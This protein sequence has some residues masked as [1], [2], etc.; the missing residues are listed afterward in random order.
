MGDPQ[1]EYGFSHILEVL[2]EKRYPHINFEIINTGVVAINSHAIRFIAD[3][4]LDWEPDLFIV[5]MGNNEVVGPYGAGTVLTAVQPNL[6]MIRLGLI[7]R[8]LRLGQLLHNALQ[9]FISSPVE[10]ERWLGMEMFIHNEVPA[11]DPRLE[12]VYANFRHNLDAICTNITK[13]KIPLVLSTVG[14]NL[15]DCAPFASKHREGITNAQLSQWQT[16]V[17][18][19]T[20]AEQEQ[21]WE[22]AID[23]HTQALELDDQYADLHFRIARC[24]VRQEHAEQAYQHFVQARDLDTLRFRADS[25]IN[26]IIKE[27]ASQ[28]SPQVHL[29]DMD[30]KNRR[31]SPMGIPGDNLFYEHVHL[32]FAGNYPLA[33]ECVRALDEVLP[34]PVTQQRMETLLSQEECARHLAFTVWDQYQISRELL[35][36]IQ[37]APFTNQLNHDEMVE[38]LR[39]TV[40]N[41]KDQVTAQITQIDESY[42]WAL[43]QHP[44]D[45]NLHRRYGGFLDHQNDL[46]K[47]LASARLIVKK[48]PYRAES[49]HILGVAHYKSGHFA[50]AKAAYYQALRMNPNSSETHTSLGILYLQQNDPGSATVHF[51]EAIRINPE[52]ERAYN[53]L[54]MIFGQQGNLKAA[55]NYFEKVLELNPKDPDAFNNLGV[56]YLNTEHYEK[57]VEMFQHSLAI[58]PQ[59]EQ[60]RD[61]LRLA[62]NRLQYRK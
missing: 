1:P 26:Q 59:Q 8:S 18:T 43:A 34:K 37:L 49:Y 31:I 41:L 52:D 33:L 9:S 54:G 56:V 40:N 6:T 12:R 61:N 62:Q 29:V 45:V 55:K 27:I 60:A 3:D 28:Y 47:M 39:Q 58:D 22:K 16:L 24:H 2:L 15:R 25:R 21:E 19:G 32:N 11:S 23:F 4:C 44:E 36:R 10:Q 48:Q 50:E 57:A 17:E 5:Y 53:N 7:L 20:Q 14:T 13:R 30:E 42:Q 38:N 46:E 35:A 51:Q